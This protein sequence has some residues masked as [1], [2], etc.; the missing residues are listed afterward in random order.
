MCMPL[1]V[2]VVIIYVFFVVCRYG[3]TVTVYV[4]SVFHFPFDC[5]NKELSSHAALDSSGLKN[6]D[7]LPPPLAQCYSRKS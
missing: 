7:T 6:C 4:V 1:F 3:Y 2:V 5:R